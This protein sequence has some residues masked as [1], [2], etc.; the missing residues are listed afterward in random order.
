MKRIVVASMSES[1]GKTS[2]IVGI[3]KALGKQI[4]YLKPF[5]DRLL[6][7][8][9]R[10]W[11][12][13]AALIARIFELEEK[14]EDITVGFRHAKLSYMVDEETARERFQEILDRVAPGSEFLFVEAGKGVAHGLSIH[15]DPFSL[16]R[17]LDGK[18][19]FVVSGA[20]EDG[21]M[22]AL[23]ALQKYRQSEKD[24]LAGV[25]INKINDMENYREV[26]LPRIER[27]GIPVL[28]LLP[29]RR[30]LDCLSA[31]HLVDRLFAK[32]LAGADRLDRPIENV[33]ATAM[34]V[35]EALKH[36]LFSAEGKLVILRGDQADLIAAA[37][38][39]DTACL[40]L[41]DGIK[42]PGE[43]SQRAQSLGVPV[44]LVS[45]DLLAVA[46]QVDRITP[47]LTE[48]DAGKISLLEA[49]ARKNIRLEA[50]VS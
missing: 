32:V 40:L 33:F 12:Y 1:D 25:I 5:G 50:L 14:P 21:G 34:D 26:F 11:D 29:Y 48:G 27:T 9:K 4:G 6:Y 18:L 42:P 24:G 43:L 19:L 35:S 49:L 13:D 8:K 17:Y 7:R 37:L 38:D 46:K 39:T 45:T 15:L 16:R 47:L 31:R 23:L 20:E 10:L 44:L 3:A 22:D 2:V 30:E 36:P 28:G 41:T